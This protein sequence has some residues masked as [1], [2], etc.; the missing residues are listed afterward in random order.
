MR[1]FQYFS[2]KMGWYFRLHRSEHS[3]TE[4]FSRICG[5]L[6][7]RSPLGSVCAAAARFALVE[8]RAILEFVPLPDKAK[9]RR[10]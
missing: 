10:C 5:D 6:K 8:N 7:I 3:F 4:L 1:F 2:K 9:S